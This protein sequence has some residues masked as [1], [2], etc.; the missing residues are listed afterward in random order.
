MSVSPR[1]IGTY[2]PSEMAYFIPDFS[3]VLIIRSTL[4]FPKKAFENHDSTVN[5][6]VETKNPKIL[7]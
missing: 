5:K 6:R 2:S 3:N 4:A 7:R 1:Y